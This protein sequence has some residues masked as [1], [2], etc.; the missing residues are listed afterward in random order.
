M[1]C[2]RTPRGC[3]P[4]LVSC[5]SDKGLILKRPNMICQDTEGRKCTKRGTRTRTR[6]HARKQRA[7]KSTQKH[8]LLHQWDTHADKRERGSKEGNLALIRT[9]SAPPVSMTGCSPSLVR[10]AY[11]AKVCLQGCL[12]QAL[13]RR[14]DAPLGDLSCLCEK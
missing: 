6:T 5:D 12:F 11:L 2:S 13:L 1:D 8:V 10:S 7:L 14:V 3:L 9:S 4:F